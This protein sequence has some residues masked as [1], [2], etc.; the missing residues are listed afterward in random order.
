MLSYVLSGDNQKI[1]EAT[2]VLKVYTKS[3][4]CVGPLAL[5]IS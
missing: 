3:V 1:K 5:I 2:N 4:N